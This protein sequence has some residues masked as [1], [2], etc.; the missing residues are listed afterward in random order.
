MVKAILNNEMIQALSG[1][2]GGILENIEG[3]FELSERL[4]KEGTLEKAKKVIKL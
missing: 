2:K 4:F 1:L 3:T